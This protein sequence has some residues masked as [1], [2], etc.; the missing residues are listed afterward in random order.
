MRD[1][2]AVYLRQQEGGQ[3]YDA[4]DSITLLSTF[5]KHR[6]FQEER[7]VR[8]VA[9]EPSPKFQS[10]LANEITTPFRKIYSFLRNGIAV[11]CIYLFEDQKLKNLPIRRIIVGPHPDKLQRKRAVEILLQN[12]GIHADVSVSATPFRGK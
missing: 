7:E 6:G 12:H 11:P 3:D 5:W 1:K 2:F 8:I 10:K 9:S 4:F